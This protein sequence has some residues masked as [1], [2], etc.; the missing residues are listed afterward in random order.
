M[1][2]DRWAFRVI[3]IYSRFLHFN[4]ISFLYFND[5]WRVRC[6]GYL[7]TK[8]P[9]AILNEDVGRLQVLQYYIESLSRS[10]H[11]TPTQALNHY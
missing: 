8:K 11:H 7:R 1:I 2:S 10:S 4:I 5:A 3:L 9:H 6:T